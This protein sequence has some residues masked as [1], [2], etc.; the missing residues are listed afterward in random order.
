MRLSLDVP[1][2]K[3]TPFAHDSEKETPKC[4][5]GHESRETNQGEVEDAASGRW[6]KVVIDY[7]YDA[8]KSRELL[9]AAHEHPGS[10]PLRHGSRQ[11]VARDLEPAIFG[12]PLRRLS[13]E[14]CAGAE[15]GV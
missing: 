13:R 12:G 4:G 7:L 15:R 14:T 10:S 9:A 2:P 11:V 5:P 6:V 8:A 3:A 1:E